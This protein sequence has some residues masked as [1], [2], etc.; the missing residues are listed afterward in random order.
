[1][2]R[3][4]LVISILSCL[5]FGLHNA[6]G[7]KILI[8]N[9]LKEYTTQNYP[10]KIYIQTDKPYYTAGENIWFNTY[11]VNGVNHIKSEKRKIIYVELINEKDSIISE[12]RLFADSI[13]VK[14][15]FKLPIDLKEGKYLLRAYT[16]YMRNELD[17][18]FFKK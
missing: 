9:K 11:L 5:A 3:F 18:F 8:L 10:E 7:L 16:N 2:K 1:M 4:L 15:D 14:G 13:S 12:G 6:S 17:D